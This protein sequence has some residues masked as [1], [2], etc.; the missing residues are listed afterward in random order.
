[1]HS[2]SLSLTLSRDVHM[3]QASQHSPHARLCTYA[4]GVPYSY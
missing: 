3:L 4:L 1:M 2:F